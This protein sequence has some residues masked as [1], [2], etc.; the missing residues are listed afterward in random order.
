MK[1]EY[2]ES[3][4]SRRNRGLA[5]SPNRTEIVISWDSNKFNVRKAIG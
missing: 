5:R 2:R 1:L 4:Q 3:R